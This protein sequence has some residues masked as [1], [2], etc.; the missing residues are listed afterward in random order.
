MQKYS[1][2]VLG[3]SVVQ[4]CCT[5]QQQASVRD[6]VVRWKAPVLTP[7]PHRAGNLTILDHDSVELSNLHR[8]VLHTEARVGVNKAQ[9]ALEGLTASAA[10]HLA[11]PRARF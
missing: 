10:S 6:A 5:L 1:L 3:G 11:H 8:Q 4:S 2:S 9:S 7:W